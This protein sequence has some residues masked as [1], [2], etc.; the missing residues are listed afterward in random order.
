MSSRSGP[1][2]QA[3]GP[4][5]T[6]RSSN[7]AIPACTASRKYPSNAG[8]WGSGATGGGRPVDGAVWV[9]LVAV[10]GTGP[11]GRLA[12]WMGPSTCSA[13]FTGRWPLPRSRSLT[14]S[15]NSSTVTSPPTDPP[16]APVRSVSTTEAVNTEGSGASA[17]P[18]DACSTA[19][20][21]ST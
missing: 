15:N 19:E 18:N 10:G 7:A 4:P 11:R 6:V 13:D 9:L 16:A 1:G 21:D 20:E 14:A 2:R 5:E 12:I 8:H 3:N 17:P